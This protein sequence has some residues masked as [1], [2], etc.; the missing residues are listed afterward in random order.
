M[1]KKAARPVFRHL[2]AT[3]HKPHAIPRAP[4]AGGAPEAVLAAELGGHVGAK[5]DAHAT[6]R[7]GHRRPRGS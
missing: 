3:H 4:V 6:V 7:P 5:L 1:A 2:M